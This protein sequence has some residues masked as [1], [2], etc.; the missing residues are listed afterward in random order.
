MAEIKIKKKAPIW[1][2]ILGL[3][4]IGAIVYFLVFADDSTDDVDD[5]TTTNTEQPMDQDEMNNSNDLRNVSE[6]NDYNSYV[7]NPDMDVDHEYSSEA[8]TKLIAA[9]SATANGLDIDINADMSAA[10]SLANEIKNDPESLKHANK[11]KETAQKIAQALKT[12]QSEKFP[13]FSSQYA[14]VE[15]AVSNI[16]VDTPTL[17]QKNAVKAFFNKAGNLLTSIQNN[18]GQSQ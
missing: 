11:I 14:E 4:I 18:D 16:N 15:T 2:W 13:Q 6:I 1:P 8:L 12:I 10:N 7:S 3:L 9:T 17:D 5:V